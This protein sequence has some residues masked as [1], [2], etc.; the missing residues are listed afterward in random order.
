MG[1]TDTTAGAV[2]AGIV[3]DTPLEKVAK[4]GST[5]PPDFATFS[6]LTTN[7]RRRTLDF[8]LTIERDGSPVQVQMKFAAIAPKAY[9]ALVAKCP[10]SPQDKLDG[11][12]FDLDKFAPEL[13]SAVSLVPELSVE[14]AREIWA[15]PD[16]APGELS[17]LFI[18][19]Q[20]VCNS[21]LDVPFNAR[22]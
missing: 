12:I 8:P 7:K 5:T 10:P 6:D 14:Q 16:W 18:N 15:N 4:K 22:G 3:D 17:S 20:R 19:A 2:A 11:A 9:D 13:I 1:R 21:G